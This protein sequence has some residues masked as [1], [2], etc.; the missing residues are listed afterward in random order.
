MPYSWFVV[1]CRIGPCYYFCCFLD[2]LRELL[3]HVWLCSAAGLD[4]FI[5]EIP[6]EVF[7]YTEEDPM[8]F[9]EARA[10][11][12]PYLVRAPSSC[13]A[14]GTLTQQPQL[15]NIGSGV[16]IIKVSGPQQFERI[17]GSSVRGGSLPSIF[18]LNKPMRVTF[19]NCNSSLVA[20]LCGDCWRC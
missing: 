18:F 3:V 13:A 9:E 20:V 6:Y 11:V 1:P 16:S 5:T 7:T 2:L 4:F 17:G 15:V 19:A 14:R 10:D 8:H 12:Y